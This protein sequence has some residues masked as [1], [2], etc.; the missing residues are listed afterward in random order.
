MLAIFYVYPLSKTCI[1]L[2][3]T[4]TSRKKSILQVITQSTWYEH[5]SLSDI[6]HNY[7]AFMDPTELL[8]E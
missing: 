4:P 1:R 5:L 8:L 2:K 7:L 3:I 6:N